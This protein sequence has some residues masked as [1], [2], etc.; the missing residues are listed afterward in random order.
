MIGQ[1]IAGN[2]Q[3][4]HKLYI[5]YS[6]AMYNVAMRILNCREDAEEALQDGFTEA[7]LKLDTFRHESTFGAWL[8]TIVVH[9]SINILRKRKVE[10]VGEEYIPPIQNDTESEDETI[11]KIQDVKR[12]IQA[13]EELPH[14]FRVVF[15]LY[16]LEGY[17]H[18]E[19]A[20]I[21]NISESTSKSQLHRAKI[22]IRE[23][24]QNGS[25][26]LQNE[27]IHR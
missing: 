5:L 11:G 7:F 26:T 1:G 9:K 16:M 6:R 17:D 15:S 13:M 23:L 4:L 8:K 27:R 21:L 12:I 2:R 18:E 22:K 25:N 3:A 19:I 24:L 14:G 20:G 10:W